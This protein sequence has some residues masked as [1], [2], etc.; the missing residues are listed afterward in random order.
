[1]ESLNLRYLILLLASWIS[2]GISLLFFSTIM[3]N[4]YPNF[5]CFT[6]WELCFAIQFLLFLLSAVMLLEISANK[7]VQKR[8]VEFIFASFSFLLSILLSLS[9]IIIIAIASFSP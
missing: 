8:S 6:S 4:Y 3:F 1:M 7:L 2:I 9:A 5:P